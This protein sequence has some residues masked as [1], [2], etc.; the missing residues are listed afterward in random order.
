M[1]GRLKRVAARGA[2]RLLS[3]TVVVS[4][5]V[6]SAGVPVVSRVAKDR[7]QPFPCQDN[8]CGCASADECWHHCCCHTNREK[9]AWAHEHGVTPPDFVV[10]AAEKEEHSA[11]HTCC[12]H[13]G[14]EKCAAKAAAHHDE[15]SHTEQ[16]AAKSPLQNPPGPGRLRPSLPQPAAVLESRFGGPPRADRA[17]LVVRRTG[18]WPRDRRR[19]CHSGASSLL[20]PFHLPS[21]ARSAESGRIRRAQAHASQSERSRCAFA[22]CSNPAVSRSIFVK[23]EVGRTLQAPR[24][25][26]RPGLIET[27]FD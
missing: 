3:I 12:T 9:V 8:P 21:L 22:N 14:C 23:R 11:E 17:G 24:S 20:P 6:G 7:S 19:L 5:L 13:H 18:R 26:Q 25:S 16:A 10:A 27:P 15:A 2:K 1:S 4:L